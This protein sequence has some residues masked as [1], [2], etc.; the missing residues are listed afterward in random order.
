LNKHSQT[1]LTPNPWVTLTL[2]IHYFVFGRLHS[3]SFCQ[4]II[5]YLTFSYS[6]FK[7]YILKT[8]WHPLN[9]QSHSLQI[10]FSSLKHTFSNILSPNSLPFETYI[11][12]HFVTQ[13][14]TI[15]NIHSQTFCHSTHYH[16]KSRLPTREYPPINCS[17]YSPTIAVQ[18]SVAPNMVAR[19]P[20]ETY[21]C[22]SCDSF[23]STWLI[24][25][26]LPMKHFDHFVYKCNDIME[27]PPP[28]HRTWI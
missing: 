2:Q 9:C 11:C 24:N 22:H 15:W 10:P 4:P 14:I 8:F 19:S 12:K 25:I 17:N 5:K 27:S 7:T 20:F 1:F 26:L 13:L 23:C 28:P 18:K 21:S 3:Q 16:I 6:F